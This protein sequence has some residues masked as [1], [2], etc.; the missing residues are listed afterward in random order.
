MEG[1]RVAPWG[2]ARRPGAEE[3]GSGP[4]EPG[5]AL[6]LGKVSACPERA[7]A[8]TAE[9]NSGG[10]VAE[11]SRKQGFEDRSVRPLNYRTG[12]WLPR[13]RRGLSGAGSW[14]EGRGTVREAHQVR[15]SPAFTPLRGGRSGQLQAPVLSRGGG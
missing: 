1:A 13:R 3:G 6:G 5:A 10:D 15:P 7:R 4:G 11:R 14:G 9:D 2:S 8:G 12:E